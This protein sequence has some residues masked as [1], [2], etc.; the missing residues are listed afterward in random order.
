MRARVEPRIAA[1]EARDPQIALLQ[2]SVV[3]V[4]D[5]KLAAGRRLYVRRNVE[6][7]IVVEIQ[8]GDGPVGL[9][10]G[11][12]LLDRFRRAGRSIERD[13]AIALWVLD[14]IGEDGRAAFLIPRA[15]CERGQARTIEDVVTEDQRDGV[16][17]DEITADNERF[18]KAV[19][20]GLFGIRYGKAGLT[21]VAEPGLKR[22]HV[23]RRRDDQD[24]PNSGY[25]QDAERVIDHR[26]VIDRQQL[27]RNGDCNRI[28]PGAASASKNNTFQVGSPSSVHE[29]WKE[30]LSRKPSSARKYLGLLKGMARS[31]KP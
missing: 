10:L 6:N 2:I 31:L 19:G 15:L 18:G 27:L 4:G 28:Q 3:D 9:G 12:F 17:A 25:H 14:A 13:H 1:A 8:A 29:A 30:N 11:R 5:F 22:G 7:G 23:P 20:L 16:V 21:A 26:L 24:F